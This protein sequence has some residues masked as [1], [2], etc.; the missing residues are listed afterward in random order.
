MLWGWPITLGTGR[1][2]T[3]F[4]DDDDDVA[5]V[6]VVDSHSKIIFG[7]LLTWVGPDNY[8]IRGKYDDLPSLSDLPLLHVYMTYIE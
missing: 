7:E 2:P 5:V 8:I 1:V 4:D 6:V 3:H